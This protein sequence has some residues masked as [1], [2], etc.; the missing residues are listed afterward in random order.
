MSATP[1]HP[2]FDPELAAALARSAMPATIT[3]DMIP[4]RRSA[5]RGITDEALATLGLGARE[6]RIA[7]F[8]GGGVDLTVVEPTEPS[9]VGFLFLHGGGMIGGD[10]RAFPALLLR[11]ASELGAVV[12]GVG[13]R[14]A[15]EHPDPIPVEDCFAALEWTVAHTAEL[16]IRPDRLVVAGTSAGGGLA[17]G[18]AL[19][20]RDRGGPR[21]AALLLTSPMLDDRD[22]TVS[23]QQIDGVGVWDRTSNVTGWTAL[24]GDRRGGDDVSIYAAPARAGDLAGLPPTYLDCGSSE[25]FRDEDVAFASRI[26]AAGGRAELHVWPGAFHAFDSIAPDATLT[27]QAIAARDGWLVRTLAEQHPRST[28]AENT[29]AAGAPAPGTGTGS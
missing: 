19:L 29:T 23:T 4:A 27:K 2:P 26:W 21:I 22:R 17:A 7:G 3:A 16:S 11:W 24:L 15:P 28:E 9:G 25:V 18:T 20:A 12:V 1:P 13:Y 14:L 10:R 6:V 8:E 5:A